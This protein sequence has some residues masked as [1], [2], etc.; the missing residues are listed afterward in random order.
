MLIGE[1]VA[2]AKTRAATAP[3]AAQTFRK[4]TFASA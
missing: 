3:A 1:V 4:V 2:R